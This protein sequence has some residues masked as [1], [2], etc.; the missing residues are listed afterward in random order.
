MQSLLNEFAILLGTVLF[1]HLLRREME[2]AGGL[3]CEEWG[4]KEKLNMVAGHAVVIMPRGEANACR[5]RKLDLGEF[6]EARF[7]L[8]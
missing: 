2:G 5:E 3:S 7:V 4:R 1:V 6:R 8:S